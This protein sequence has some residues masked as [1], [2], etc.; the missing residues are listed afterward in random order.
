MNGHS[1][2][3]LDYANTVE[4]FFGEQV[5]KKSGGLMFASRQITQLMGN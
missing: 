5:P 2:M 3:E 4:T 1:L